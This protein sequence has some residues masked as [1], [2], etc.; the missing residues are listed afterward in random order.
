MDCV[1][2]K[3]V[4]GDIP[5]HNIY[6]EDDFIAFL[7]INPCNPGHTLIIPKKHYRWVWDVENAGDYF[8]A[9]KKVAKALQ[10]SLEAE[11][12][13]SGIGGTDVPHAHIHI[14]PRFKDD[15]HGS[16][17]NPEKTLK[18]PNDEMEKISEKIRKSFK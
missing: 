16:W 18:L 5:C 3:I 17:L 14:I 2:C 1:F 15:G 12:V 9:A 6:E 7:D 8:E 4:K 13:V 10:K 11:F